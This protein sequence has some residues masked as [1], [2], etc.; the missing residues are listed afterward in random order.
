MEKSLAVTDYLIVAGSAAMIE[1]LSKNIFTFVLA[2]E[3]NI[4]LIPA[5]MIDDDMEREGWS[6]FTTSEE[7]KRNFSI[8]L[9]GGYTCKQDNKNLF[10]YSF[11]NLNSIFFNKLEFPPIF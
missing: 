6:Y 8:L 3:S 1:G 2:N 7:L 5:D 9:K 11:Q 4:D 10:E